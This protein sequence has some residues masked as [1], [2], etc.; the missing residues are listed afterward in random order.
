MQAPAYQHRV[1]FP[2]ATPQWQQGIQAQSQPYGGLGPTVRL[3]H[4]QAD[5][6]AH[7]PE[8]RG[9]AESLTRGVYGKD[10]LSEI[11][12]L[13]Y[14]ACDPRNVRYMRDPHR[15]ELVKDTYVIVQTKQADCDEFDVILKNLIGALQS[16]HIAGMASAAG[17]ADV[18]PVLAGFQAERNMS[19]T[20]VRVKDPRGSGRKAVLDPVAGPLTPR[21]LRQIKHFETAGA[22]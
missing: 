22:V 21:M 12:A 8:I 20:F 10:Y 11:A 2:Q 7:S 13:Y 3:I 4:Q 16:R 17:N 18:E 6:L 1:N 14:W 15:V 9:M 5:R 19:H